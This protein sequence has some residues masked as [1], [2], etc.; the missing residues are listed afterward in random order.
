MA[1][2]DPE[3]AALKTALDMVAFEDLP[4]LPW[5][6]VNAKLDVLPRVRPT[7]TWDSGQTQV[8]LNVQDRYGSFT[9]AISKESLWDLG[10]GIA[11]FLS[12]ETGFRAQI[13]RALQ[14]QPETRPS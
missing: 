7:L 8:T 14:G 9:V 13:E 6:Q 2:T 11:R 4:G 5:R 1:F 3:I 10:L 12:A